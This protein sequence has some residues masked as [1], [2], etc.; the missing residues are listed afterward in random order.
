MTKTNANAFRAYDKE[1]GRYLTSDD[2]S[3]IT[4][5]QSGD[6]LVFDIC[7]NPAFLSSSRYIIERFTGFT[8]KNGRDIYEG[9]LITHSNS[10]LPHCVSINIEAGAIAQYSNDDT[11]IKLMSILRDIEVVATVHD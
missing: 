1:Q 6:L 4:L 3:Y 9:D 8:D 5:D 11:S 7:D 10:E 2:Y